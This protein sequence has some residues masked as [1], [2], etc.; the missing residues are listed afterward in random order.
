LALRI[1]AKAIYDRE[2][3]QPIKRGRNGI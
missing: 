1:N 2:G 3:Y